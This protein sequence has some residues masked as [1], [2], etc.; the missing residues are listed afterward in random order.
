MDIKKKG[1]L[2]AFEGGEGAG[3]SEQVKKL[4]SFFRKKGKKVVITRAPGGTEIGEQIRQVLLSL[5]NK[6]MAFLTEALL[7][8]ASRAQVTSEMIL[9]ALK[10][11]KVVIAD[12][13]RD[14]STI[15]QGVVRQLGIEMIEKLNDISTQKTKPNLTILLDVPPEIGLARRDKA[16]GKNRID[17]EKMDFHRKI[18]KAYLSWAKKNKKRFV[19]VDGKKSINEIHQTILNIFE[20]RKII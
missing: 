10:K 16:G 14:S 9:P 15:Y 4:A 18:R 11:G 8:Q 12:R 1:I 6:R 20:D 13:Y 3:K 17:M 5:K 19:V 7:F 2:L